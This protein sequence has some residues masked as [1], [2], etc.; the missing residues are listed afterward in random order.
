MP[1]EVTVVIPTRD[2]SAQ[3]AEAVSALRWA[4]EVIVVDG[5]S[6]DGTGPL[7]AAA[8][9]RVIES[10]PMTIG[11]KRNAGI[12]AASHE[13]ILALDADERVT[14]ELRGRIE[15]IVGGR[16]PRHAAYRIRFR[17]FVLGKELKHGP[18]GRDR[19]VRLFTRDRRYTTS[20]VHERLEPIADVG[21]I[22]EPIHHQPFRDFPHYI[23][24]VVQYARWGADDIR[25]RGTRVGY[26]DLL[27]RP[28]WRFIR[29]YLV[30]SGFLDGLP[31][32]LVCAYAS[33]GTFLKYCYAFVGQRYP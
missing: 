32:F 10:G 9:A 29:D 31:G 1:V 8:G 25:H 7:A 5:E 33:I 22:E 16:A 26:I 12:E 30:W 24:K 13:W 20:N 19:H 28:S 2:E 6:T 14:D 27:V 21:D 4:A 23:R 15:A 17:N 3:I 18:Y 11:A